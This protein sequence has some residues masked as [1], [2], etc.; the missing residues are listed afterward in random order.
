LGYLERA[1][2]ADFTEFKHKVGSMTESEIYEFYN[3]VYR[4]FGF[5]DY[6]ETNLP[7]FIDWVVGDVL[8]VGCNAGGLLEA[9]RNKGHAGRLVGV[10]ICEVALEEALKRKLDVYWGDVEIGLPFNSG[11]FQ[12]V[13]C[14]HT[15]EH[16]R[17]PKE[18]LAELIRV[19][20]GTVIIIIPIQG[21]EARWKKT[22][23]HLQFWPTPESFEEFAGRKAEMKRVE[24]DGTLGILVFKMSPEEV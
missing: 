16:L 2:K 24:R 12:T 1:K 13:I 6:T 20:R 4:D 17:K 21:E 11:S 15:M 22:N 10:D 14:G 8:D 7:F 3:Q 5:F 23:T 9:L 18:A 19:C